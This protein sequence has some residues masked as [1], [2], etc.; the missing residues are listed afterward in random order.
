M[1]GSLAGTSLSRPPPRPARREPGHDPEPH[2]DREPLE[3]HERD[4]DVEQEVHDAR[5][6]L[7][8]DRVHPHP[9]TKR[10]AG[11]PQ[12]GGDGERERDPREPEQAEHHRRDPVR[13]PHHP[14]A[15][16]SALLRLLRDLVAAPGAALDRGDANLRLAR[17]RSGCQHR[18][19]LGRGWFLL[20]KLQ[21]QG[22]AGAEPPLATRRPNAA[23]AAQYRAPPTNGTS[24]WC[25]PSIQSASFGSAAIS[26][27]RRPCDT[28][29]TS[30]SVPWMMSTGHRTWRRWRRLGK[31]SKG[32]RGTF[33]STRKVLTNALSSTS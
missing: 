5:G 23:S 20:R 10:L 33:V 24:L 17:D 28:G 3:Q 16:R 29:I 25:A 27:S 12:A 1:T 14:L 22:V 30:S 21:P 31:R 6:Q 4:H 18:A 19:P 13:G 9:A 11:E 7:L 15:A 26:Y 2:A 8:V 32:R